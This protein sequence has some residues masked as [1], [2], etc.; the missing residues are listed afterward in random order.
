[1]ILPLAFDLL[2]VALLLIPLACGPV[3][4]VNYYNTLA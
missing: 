4:R 1:V 3:D 2:S